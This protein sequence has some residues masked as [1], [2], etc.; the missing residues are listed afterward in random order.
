MFEGGQWEADGGE[1]ERMAEVRCALGVNKRGIAYHVSSSVGTFGAADDDPRSRPDQKHCFSEHAS[2]APV[3]SIIVVRWLVKRKVKILH[4][5]QQKQGRV[6][7]I[8]LLVL[9]CGW[10]DDR[11]Y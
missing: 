11:T 1:R 3:G 5:M 7:H 4:V 2:S 10:T 8:L 6:S 9:Q